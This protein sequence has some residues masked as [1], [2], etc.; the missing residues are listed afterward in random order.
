MDNTFTGDEVIDAYE[1][2]LSE[3]ELDFIRSVLQPS[4]TEWITKYKQRIPVSEME[5]AH[6]INTILMLERSEATAI[7][8]YPTL[9]VEARKRNLSLDKVIHREVV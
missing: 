2:M 1:H 3:A 4:Q 8:T 9:L 6:I 7:A 5:D